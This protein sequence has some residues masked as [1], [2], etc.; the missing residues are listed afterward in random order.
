MVSAA[1]LQ[2][3]RRKLEAALRRAGSVLVLEQLELLAP[4]AV[5]VGSSEHGAAALLPWLQ[6]ARGCGSIFVIGCCGQLAAVHPRVRRWFDD[7][8]ELPPP[9]SSAHR[10]LLL[11]LLCDHDASSTDGVG[12]NTLGND[13]AAGV[14]V[15]R[16]AAEVETLCT[17]QSY[18]LADVVALVKEA[19]LLASL[20]AAAATQGTPSLSAC[21]VPSLVSLLHVQHH[22]L[23][24]GL[25]MLS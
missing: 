18:V 5:Q 14:A 17:A 19:R 16:L 2:L 25:M 3:P 13:A 10:R 1:A 4:A 7:E 20:N 8:C 9:S 24:P 11:A 23:L 12:N 6:R 15:E 22:G 21:P